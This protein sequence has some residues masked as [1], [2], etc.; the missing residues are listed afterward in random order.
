VP[1]AAEVPLEAGVRPVP[2]GTGVSLVLPCLDEAESVALCVRE[3]LDAM[4][5]AG[6]DGE[7]V[8]V[9]N[10]STDGSPEIATQ[11]GARVVHEPRRGYGQALRTGFE[12]SHHDI[13]M[14]GD[15]DFTYDFTKIPL[16][17]APVAN[18][19]ADLV[20]GSRLDSATRETMPFLHRYLGTPAITFLTAR[21]CGR[22]VVTD[23]QSGYRA[24]RKDCLPQLGLS[25][26]GM[27]LA[28]EMLIKAARAGLEIQEIP[29]GYRPRIGESKLSTWSDGWRHLQLILMLAP[30]VLL[31]GPGAV[32]LGLGVV[33]LS[34]AFISPSGVG[35][36]SLRWQPVFFS[37]IAIVI[38]VLA[39]LAGTVIAHYSS[40]ATPVVRRRYEFVG[41]PTFPRRCVG[42]GAILILLGL[43]VNLVL[44]LT[45]VAGDGP[46]EHSFGLASLSQSLI[47]VGAILGSFGLI[48]RFLRVRS[49][50]EPDATPRGA[51]DRTATTPAGDTGP[52]R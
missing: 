7:V 18:G 43:V 17:V 46:S 26:T 2:P 41:R 24:F 9:D 38:G 33:M 39:L 10:G 37:G 21:A 12:A 4:V 42:A 27:E 5:A 48:S 11:A 3:A 28:S 40:V 29:T 16:L 35:I 44:F 15:A 45:W 1:A 51:G 32:L 30:D 13:V 49:E 36:G 6:I 14:M 34:L 52:D 19:E 25:S 23:S 8:V 20:L 31:I 47:L 22:R 50:T